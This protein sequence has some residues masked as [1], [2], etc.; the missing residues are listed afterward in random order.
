M[1]SNIDL[2]LNLY[3]LQMPDVGK[4][5][6]EV[7]IGKWYKSV[8]EQ[9]QIDETLLEISTDKVVSEIPSEVSGTIKDIY[10]KDGELVAPGKIIA[11]IELRN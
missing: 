2:N 4:N 6:T 7:M 11:S 1:S 8:G 5:I 9:V 10:Y 3:N